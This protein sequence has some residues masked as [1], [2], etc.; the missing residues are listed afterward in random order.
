[1]RKTSEPI[2]DAPGEIANWDP[3]EDEKE[4]GLT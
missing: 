2:E 4:G 3:D 1:M